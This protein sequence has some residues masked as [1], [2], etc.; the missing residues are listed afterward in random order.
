MSRKSN[1]SGP[2]H[3]KSHHP[4]NRWGQTKQDHPGGGHDDYTPRTASTHQ[5]HT[6]GIFG[7]LAQEILAHKSKKQSRALDRANKKLKQK[8]QGGVAMAYQGKYPAI[9]RGPAPSSSGD[10]QYVP[11]NG[12][13]IDNGPIK[14][15]TDNGPLSLK[16]RK[17]SQKGFGLPA[18]HKPG[19]ATQKRKTKVDALTKGLLAQRGR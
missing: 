9:K 2:G 7:A 14:R 15:H 1:L 10:V 19:T 12:R 11:V 8:Q 4:R 17:P 16:G 5:A 13:Q 18:L 3:G 6:A